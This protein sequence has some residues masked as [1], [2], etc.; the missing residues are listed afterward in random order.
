MVQHKYIELKAETLSREGG[1][2]KRLA[3]ES[4]CPVGLFDLVL[5]C[6]PCG[7]AP[8]VSAIL[9]EFLYQEDSLNRLSVVFSTFSQ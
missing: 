7:V 2:I 9:R 3:G 5:F 4:L 6:G 8:S 1:G